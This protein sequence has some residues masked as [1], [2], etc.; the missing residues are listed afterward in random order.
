MPSASGLK[1][2][3]QQVVAQSLVCLISFSKQHPATL[4]PL[5]SS[6]SDYTDQG[7]TLASGRWTF[8]SIDLDVW[9]Q[10]PNN[11]TLDFRQVKAVIFGQGDA[12]GEP[13]RFYIDWIRAYNRPGAQA[14]SAAQIGKVLAYPL[15]REIVFADNSRTTSTFVALQVRPSTGQPSTV[16]IQPAGQP[17]ML[18]WTATGSNNSFY[19]TLPYEYGQDLAAISIQDSLAIPATPAFSDE[20]A[21]DMVQRSTLRYFWDFRHP[22]SGLARERN[23]SLNTVTIGGSGFGLMT[24]LVGIER[25]WL[26]R[27]EVMDQLLVSLNY[28]EQADRFHGAWPHWMNGNSGRVIPFSPRDDGGDIV[29]TAFMAQALLTVREYFAG[30]TAREDSI[31]TKANRL[32]EGIEWDWYVRPG[33]D[34]ITWHWSPTQAW[35]IN[36]K[37]RGFNEAQIVYLLGIASPTHP[38]APSLYA[39]GWTGPNYRSFQGR[40]GIFI[41]AG[42]RSGGPMFFAHYS[43]QGFDPR[44]WRDDFTN[45]YARN[46]LHAEYQI[47]YAEENPLGF[48]YYN[49]DCWGLTASDDPVRGYAVHE[50]SEDNDNGTIAPTAA[51]ASMPYKPAASLDALRRFYTNYN[52]RVYGMMGFYDAFNPA[53]DWFTTAYLAID[54]G[55]I[56]N[57]IENHRSA[58]L[59]DA[60]MASPEIEPALLAAGFVPDSTTYIALG[61]R[62]VLAKA[63]WHVYPNPAVNSVRISIDSQGKLSSSPVE[64][65][66]FDALGRVGL[67]QNLSHNSGDMVLQINDLSP[68]TY[69]LRLE[70]N[71]QHL[72]TQLLNI[73]THH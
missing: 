8:I 72:G 66:L 45:Y 57:M 32:W 37:V 55:P 3:E 41:P 21:M 35:A 18:H 29:E 60:F 17:A 19:A 39:T 15:H 69:A 50:A 48:S 5:T 34:V 16:R 63:D 59:W 30:N 36:L 68:G 52:S 27:S 20:V 54:Q 4:N 47:A 70:Q 42:P 43:Y 28:L 7:R 22:V 44:F 56:V 1:L 26:D 12:D 73:T 65:I 40:N 61:T 25:G 64:V 11:S 14:G 31:R 38:I 24:W 10:D 53:L 13:H 62:S 6:L 67:R 23:T 33:E 51:L 58:V 2:S 9:R 49:E 46:R 71:G